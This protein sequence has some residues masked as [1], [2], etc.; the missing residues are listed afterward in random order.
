MASQS[1]P[2]PVSGT[3]TRIDL[4]GVQ[5]ERC[6]ML[7]ETVAD[8]RTNSRDLRFI[9]GFFE[10]ETVGLRKEVEYERGRKAELEEKV[11]TLQKEIQRLNQENEQLEELAGLKSD[12]VGRLDTAL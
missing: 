9:L 1:V 10:R 8:L 6:A 7:T 5:A 3:V 4:N 11:R 12:P 2:S